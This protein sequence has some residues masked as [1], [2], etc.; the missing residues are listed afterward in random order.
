MTESKN[1][2]AI[3][4]VG[5][6]LDELSVSEL[7]ERVGALEEEITRVRAEIVNKKL[8]KS[9]AESVFKL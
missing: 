6:T 4:R 8:K 3:I 2:T 5:E 1:R 7:E 9:D